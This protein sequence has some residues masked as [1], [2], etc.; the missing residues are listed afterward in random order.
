MSNRFP[1]DVGTRLGETDLDPAERARIDEA[2]CLELVG[3]LDRTWHQPTVFVL[4][5]KDLR[6]GRVRNCGA[7]DDPQNDVVLAAE[8]VS[9][10]HARI[11]KR[12][13][14]WWC[15]DEGSSGGTFVNDARLTGE[16]REMP[17]QS[18]DRI[19]FGPRVSVVCRGAQEGREALARE[20]PTPLARLESTL[21]TNADRVKRASTLFHELDRALRFLAASAFALLRRAAELD[22]EARSR[23]VKV[24][25][26]PE[27]VVLSRGRELS[28]GAWRSLFICLAKL[29][30]D[31]DRS[32]LVSGL[33]L[34][35]AEVRA[36]DDAIKL[37][38]LWAHGHV[39]TEREL[40][41][42]EPDLETLVGALLRAFAPFVNLQLTSVTRT[43][44]LV[45]G[46]RYGVHI[47]RGNARPRFETLDCAAKMLSK[48]CY[49]LDPIEDPAVAQPLLLA[50]LLAADETHEG[51]RI[52]YAGR[53]D[54]GPKNTPVELTLAEGH[55]E[56]TLLPIPWFSAFELVHE[57]VVSEPR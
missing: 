27:Y 29:L 47:L 28:T 1:G 11:E 24:L 57:G 34:V 54:L 4:R 42:A 3:G 14:Q 10:R 45:D 39:P 9:R 19:R 46:Y 23:L 17:L 25:L 32:R 6:I 31:T 50:P 12:G 16:I 18:G 5:G 30:P 33:K 40:E 20:L 41:E 13:K 7:P 21:S 56:P 49:L 38:N 53:L 48:W 2:Y 15:R 22:S 35:S 37:R 55:V 36:V 52:L 8:S 44:N 26:R 43:E 51:H